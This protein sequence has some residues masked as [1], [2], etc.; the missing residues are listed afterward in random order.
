MLLFLASCAAVERPD[1]TRSAFGILV[2]GC[3]LQA[4][5][6]ESIVWG[7]PPSRLGRLPRAALLA[8]EER[9]TL[10]CICMGTAASSTPDGEYEAVVLARMLTRRCHELSQFSAF[11]GIPLRE[12]E[13]LLRSV[14]HTDLVSTNT[15]EEVTE[16]LSRFEAAGVTRAV[17]VSSPTHLPRCLIE[18]CAVLERQP[19]LFSGTLL[20][21]P[22]D[23]CYSGYS[24]ADVV[25]VEPPHRGDRDRSLDRWPLHELVRRQFALDGPRRR[26]LLERLDALLDEAEAE[27]EAEAEVC[28]DAVAT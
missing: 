1:P 5:G 2:H 19:T 15:R 22:S 24:S 4:E 8:W 25:V 26:H 14:V 7:I 6:W 13:L 23:T 27:A 9:D 10:A 12:L 17:L 18:G 3:H 21:C 16:G 28:G 20:A 11:Q